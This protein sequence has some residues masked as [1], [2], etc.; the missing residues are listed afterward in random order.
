MCD[1]LKEKGIYRNISYCKKCD[2][3]LGPIYKKG[4]IRTINQIKPNNSVLVLDMIDNPTKLKMKKS[5]EN[6]II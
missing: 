1:H 3:V 6:V 5:I 2:L 4:Y